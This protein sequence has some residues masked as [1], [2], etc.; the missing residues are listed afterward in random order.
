MRAVQRKAYMD[1]A[2]RSERAMIRRVARNLDALVDNA[3]AE[4][5]DDQDDGSEPDLP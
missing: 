2:H 4:A 1:G 3:K 5:D